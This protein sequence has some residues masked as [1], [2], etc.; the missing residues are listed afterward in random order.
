MVDTVSISMVKIVIS[1]E[2]SE[3][4]PSL[5]D[6]ESSLE[7]IS[8]EETIEV[9]WGNTKIEHVALKRHQNR[10]FKLIV[11]DLQASERAIA[12]LE[13]PLTLDSHLVG[14]ARVALLNKK[15][16][17]WREFSRNMGVTTTKHLVL[18]IAADEIRSGK[19]PKLAYVAK[20][21]FLDGVTPTN[22]DTLLRLRHL[23]G[24]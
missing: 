19:K 20:D 24:F 6:I 3:A 21:M 10:K 18:K 16:Y 23:R 15:L 4:C 13:I 11:P 1:K 12:S 17:N 22:A 7:N 2:L 14:D 8:A 5:L 9:S